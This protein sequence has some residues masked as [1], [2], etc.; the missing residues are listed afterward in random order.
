MTALL[1]SLVS[2]GLAPWL[3]SLLH[4]W[5]RVHDTLDRL[6]VGVIV[7]IVLVEV[8]VEG[9][10][11][12]GWVGPLLGVV[13]MALPSLIEQV[14]SRLA[15][16]THSLTVLLGALALAVHSLMDGATLAAADDQ[17]L[18]IAVVLH[19]LPLGLAI[20]W[21]VRHA[22]SRSLAIATLMAMGLATVLGFV[23]TQQVVPVLTQS[24]S[25]GLQAFLA[26]ALLH[27]LLHRHRPRADHAGDGL[28]HSGHQHDHGNQQHHQHNHDHKHDHK[29]GHD[30]HRH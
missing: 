24:T 13:A 19:Q 10:E 4:R 3:Y 12:I 18:A 7:L 1:I 8:F 25:A 2:L 5:R 16:P 26:G 11:Q 22:L 30:H 28:G 29:H 20:W 27:V 9:Y 17:W 15:L 14:F 6:L 21:L 23:L